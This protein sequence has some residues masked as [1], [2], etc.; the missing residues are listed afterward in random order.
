[1]VFRSLGMI[2]IV[3]FKFLAR[4]LTLECEM[5]VGVIFRVTLQALVM[6][7]CAGV[8]ASN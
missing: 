8:G 4:N 3:M 1:M 6:K 2:E 7:Q 5:T